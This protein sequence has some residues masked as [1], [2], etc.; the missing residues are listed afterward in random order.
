MGK[1][2]LHVATND[3]SPKVVKEEVTQSDR[4]YYLGRKETA[5]GSVSIGL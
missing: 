1:L 4:C 5:V 3:I 2:G